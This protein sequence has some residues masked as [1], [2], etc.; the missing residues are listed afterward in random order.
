MY[1]LS[2][3]H[4]HSDLTYFI[5][6]ALRLTGNNRPYSEVAEAVCRLR[7]CSQDLFDLPL[8]ITHEVGETSFES[9]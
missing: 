6:E 8:P 7:C 4:Y 1:V 2:S 9:F 3:P 5:L